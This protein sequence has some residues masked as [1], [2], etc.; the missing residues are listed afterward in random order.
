[1]DPKKNVRRVL[2]LSEDIGYFEDWR[3][4]TLLTISGEMCNTKKE[5]SLFGF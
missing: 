4:V 5:K 1:M 3:G 2:R